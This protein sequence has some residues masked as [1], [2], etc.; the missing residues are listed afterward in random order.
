MDVTTEFIA[1]LNQNQKEIEADMGKI[2]K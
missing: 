1:Y 2:K